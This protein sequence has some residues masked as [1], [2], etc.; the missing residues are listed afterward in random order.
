MRFGSLFSKITLKYARTCQNQQFRPRHP[1]NQ[2]PAER[3]QVV[4]G[5][6]FLHTPPTDRSFVTKLMKMLYFTFF[7]STFKPSEFPWCRS[8]LAFVTRALG[9]D[10][11]ETTLIY[12]LF[13]YFLDLW[14]SLEVLVDFFRISSD[15][16]DVSL[17]NHE[18]AR[19]LF[20]QKWPRVQARP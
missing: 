7:L 5:S 17:E 15:R 2:T 9:P 11:H 18:N 13:D 14:T 6:S 1:A 19:C 12:V 4:F 3:A 8:W 10:L 16:R 20:G